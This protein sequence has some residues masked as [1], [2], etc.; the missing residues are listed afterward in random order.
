[1]VSRKNINTS[2]IIQNEPDEP[3]LFSCVWGGRACVHPMIIGYDLK[4][5]RGYIGN[6]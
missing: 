2:K 3:F 1:M 6:L 5:S 4:Q